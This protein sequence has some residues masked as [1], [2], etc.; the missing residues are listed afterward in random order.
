MT[1]QSTDVPDDCP[2]RECPI[3]MDL[4]V[5]M[6]DMAAFRR[7]G[8]ILSGILSA[9]IIGLCGWLAGVQSAINSLEN[10]DAD[11]GARLVMLEST[12]RMMVT[13]LTT[14]G[15]QGATQQEAISQI[16]AR[17]ASMEAKLDRLL[18]RGNGNGGTK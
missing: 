1:P 4:L 12:Q 14:Q 15:R 9:A 8:T 6:K 13:E 5:A 11:R 17:L 10:V 2:V 3:D 7:V 18:E 16:T